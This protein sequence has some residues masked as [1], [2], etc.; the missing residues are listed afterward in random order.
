MSKT[1]IEMWD[2]TERLIADWKE[3]AATSRLMNTHQLSVDDWMLYKSV[4]HK[5]DA[6][7]NVYDEKLDKF[8]DIERSGDCPEYEKWI[9]GE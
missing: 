3:E 7:L 1:L 4:R 2:D 9:N 5:I 8:W 6:V